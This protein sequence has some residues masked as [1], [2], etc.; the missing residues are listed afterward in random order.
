MSAPKLK[1]FVKFEDLILF[2]DDDILLV[3][4]PLH[5]ASL[6]DKSRRNLN[7]LSKK[8]NPEL[9]LSHRLDKMTSGVLLMAKGQDNYRHIALQFQH[10][11]VKKQYHTIVNGVYDFDAHD[12]SPVCTRSGIVQFIK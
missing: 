9:S 3:N 2:E 5:M 7:H 11:K 12:L 6:D 10:R 1:K 8:Y 4:K